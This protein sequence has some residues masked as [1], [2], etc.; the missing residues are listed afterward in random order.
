[1]KLFLLLFAV[2]SFLFA[3]SVRTDRKCPAC[4][5]ETCRWEIRAAV[6]KEKTEIT[7]DWDKS[8]V[9]RHVE[10]PLANPLHCNVDRSFD[11]VAGGY[12]K[13]WFM[14][15]TEPCDPSKM[16]TSTC[17]VTYLF[18]SETPSQFPSGFSVK[19]PEG[20]KLQKVEHL[21]TLNLACG[22]FLDKKSTDYS[23]WKATVGWTADG[24]DDGTYASE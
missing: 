3:A 22:N 21:S 18:A 19:A 14:G 11:H 6:N 7:V 8:V 16:E 13:V 20:K 12:I 2:P 17:G 1:M 15:E 10:K 5:D 23:K 4:V 9:S 24:A